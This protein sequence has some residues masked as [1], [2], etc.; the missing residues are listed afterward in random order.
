[1]S[2]QPDRVVVE[3]DLDPTVAYDIAFFDEFARAVGLSACGGNCETTVGLLV[4]IRLAP[5]ESR[6]NFR[7]LSG[8]A[9]SAA[10][11]HQMLVHEVP[12]VTAE[13]VARYAGLTGAPRGRWPCRPWLPQ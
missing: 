5:A 8:G 4:R 6:A 11:I 9:P 13:A 10:P 2:A 7:Y 1:M 3:L 12:C